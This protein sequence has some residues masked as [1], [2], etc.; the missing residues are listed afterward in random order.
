[1]FLAVFVTAL[2]GLNAPASKKIMLVQTL[3]GI[4]GTAF[5]GFLVVYE[6]FFLKF[7][8]TP[9]PACLFGLVFYLGILVTSIVGLR[10]TTAPEPTP[11]NRV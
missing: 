7:P 9:I 5:S 3:L 8:L 6:I 10:A 2:V 11:L 1:M 4:A